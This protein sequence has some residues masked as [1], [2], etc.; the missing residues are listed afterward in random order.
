MIN[1]A[2]LRQRTTKNTPASV[3]LFVDCP[4]DSFR[5]KITTPQIFQCISISVSET[6][7]FSRVTRRPF[8]VWTKL[9]FWSMKNIISTIG[10]DFM[11]GR[12]DGWQQRAKQT[13]RR[14]QALT[15]GKTDRRAVS[16]FQVHITAVKLCH[17]LFRR[18]ASLQTVFQEFGKVRAVESRAK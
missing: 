10:F 6:S 5:G 18:G 12:T 8:F 16:N 17:G 2:S 9:L 13:R 11:D 1:T 14:T 7:G 4:P 3:H 15:D